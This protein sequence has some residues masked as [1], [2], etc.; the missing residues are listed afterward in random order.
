MKDVVVTIMTIIIIIKTITI[1]ID[2]KSLVVMVERFYHKILKILSFGHHKGK[3]LQSALE[4]VI[5]IITIIFHFLI[6][7]SKIVKVEKLN[8]ESKKT[9][10]ATMGLN[11]LSQVIINLALAI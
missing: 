2:N 10:F 7:T 5:D 8:A 6:K 3:D 11:V 9:T 4:E 1:E